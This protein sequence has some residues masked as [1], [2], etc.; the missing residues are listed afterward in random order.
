MATRRRLAEGRWRIVETEMWDQESLD[1]VVPAHI[2]FNRNG[3]GEMQMI[4]IGASVDY[5]VEERGGA[6]VVEFSWSGFDEMEPTSG[7]GWASVEGDTMHGKLFIHQGDES[8]F[9]AK[10][11]RVVRRVSGSNRSLQP[12]AA[13]RSRRVRTRRGIF[14]GRG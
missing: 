2:T 8:S 10:R 14:R 12:P 13:A 7:R 5:R 11:D 4:A 1:L 3:L 6:P 9:V